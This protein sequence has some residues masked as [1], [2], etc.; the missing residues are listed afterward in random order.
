MNRFTK[1]LVLATVSIATLA[2]TFEMASARDRYP[3]WRN[4][5]HR[6]AHIGNKA[7]AAGALG[8]AAGVI[9]GNAL[10]EP[11]PVYRP[12]RVY[13]EPDVVYEGPVETYREPPVRDDLYADEDGYFPDRP[14]VGRERERVAERGTY[15]PWSRQWRNWCSDRYKS[16]NPSTGTYRGYDGRD[17]FCTAG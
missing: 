15:E 10:S 14:D 12:R 8:L 6:G 16:F 2:G 5:H 17:H 9:I 4:H 11:R 13:V 3:Y 7:F 1:S